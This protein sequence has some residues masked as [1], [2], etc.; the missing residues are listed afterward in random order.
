MRADHS[1][2]VALFIHGRIANY[3]EERESDDDDNDNSETATPGIYGQIYF[4]SK[5][6]A[7]TL[8]ELLLSDRCRDKLAFLQFHPK[9]NTFLT[10]FFQANRIPLPGNRRIN[11]T[12]DVQVSH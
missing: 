4:G 9:L 6:K 10:V 7:C 1:A 11:I 5:Q 8:A 12:K 3:E 2:Y